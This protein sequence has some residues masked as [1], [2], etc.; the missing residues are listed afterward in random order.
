MTN[1]YG[2][3]MGSAL[4]GRINLFFGIHSASIGYRIFKYFWLIL[5]TIPFLAESVI[6]FLTLT[7]LAIIGHFF[8]SLGLLG[9]LPALLMGG[10]YTAFNYL[11]MLLFSFFTLPDIT[12]R[13]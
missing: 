4:L 10:V 8:G 5:F 1:T 9:L 6:E 12:L 3:P 11:F 13:K 2:T 7:I